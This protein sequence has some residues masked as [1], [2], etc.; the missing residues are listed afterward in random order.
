MIG[1]KAGSFLDE[2]AA[3]LVEKNPH[4]SSVTGNDIVIISSTNHDDSGMAQM[5]VSIKGYRGT[6]TLYYKS[7][8]AGSMQNLFCQTPLYVKV[9]DEGKVSILDVWHEYQR[10]SGI[11]TIEGLKDVQYWDT[12]LDIP[13]TGFVDATINPTVDSPVWITRTGQ[14]NVLVKI[15]RYENTDL[16]SIIT[17]SETAPF[18]DLSATEDDPYVKVDAN[19][20]MPNTHA[21]F[22]YRLAAYKAHNT[23]HEVML[24]GA[25]LPKALVTEMIGD[26]SNNPNEVALSEKGLGLLNEVLVLQALRPF[27]KPPVFPAG[28]ISTYPTAE[29]SDY[30]YVDDEYTT[31]IT[32]TNVRAYVANDTDDYMENLIVMATKSP[33]LQGKTVF[34]GRIP[35]AGHNTFLYKTV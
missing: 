14:D 17:T 4:M 1:F 26:G 19:E 10:M 33:Q 25:A 9:N 35:P 22:L 2:I 11:K 20:A 16:G 23:M 30:A 34:I 27:D 7:L 28:S 31:L 32:S 13:E 8:K 5:E 29:G 15:G 12:M 6:T 24:W 21:P 18:F 3:L